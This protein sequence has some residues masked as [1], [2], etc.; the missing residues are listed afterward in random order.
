MLKRLDST[1]TSGRSDKWIKMKNWKEETIT[2]NQYEDSPT[3]IVLISGE[4]RVACN[5]SQAQPVKDEL[6]TKGTV[7][8]EIQFREKFTHGSKMRF[9]TFKRMTC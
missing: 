4:N 1:Y 5:G 6:I 2:F 8:A 9:P 7:K 3:G